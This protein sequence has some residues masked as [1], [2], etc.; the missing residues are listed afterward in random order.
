MMLLAFLVCLTMLLVGLDIRRRWRAG[1]P[2]PTEAY[3]LFWFGGP[4]YTAVSL[5]C[6][7]A[8][9]ETAAIFVVRTLLG[10][11]GLPLLAWGVRRYVL[12]RAPDEETK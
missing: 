4:L 11:L 7:Y 12:K 3:A 10:W 9:R 5:A 1:L 8:G 6:H 2:G